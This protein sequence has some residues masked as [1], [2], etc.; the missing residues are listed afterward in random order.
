MDVRSGYLYAQ[1]SSRQQGRQ[2]YRTIYSASGAREQMIEEQWRVLLAEGLRALGETLAAQRPP[3][4][5]PH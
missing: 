4:P 5:V 3:E 1:L 2:R